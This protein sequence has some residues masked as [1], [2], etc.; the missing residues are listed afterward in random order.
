M[1]AEDDTFGVSPDGYRL[2]GAMRLGCVRL[3][4]SDLARSGAYYQRVIGLQ[5][6]DQTPGRA[7]LGAGGLAGPLIELHE[8]PHVRPVPRRGRIGLFH[9]AV[10]LPDRASLGRFIAHV[11]DLGEPAGT[12][13]HAVS[14]SVYLWDPDGLGIEVYAD[15]P[16]SEWRR[17]GR[18]L[19]MTTAPLDIDDL[20]SAAAGERWTGVPAGTLM[21]HVHLHVGDL[22]RAEAFYHSTLGFDKTVWSYPGAL[23]FAAGGYHHHLGTNIWAADT[24][25]AGPG[26]A[27]LLEWEIVLDDAGQAEAAARSCEA[28]GF[29]VT[30]RD[31]GFLVPDPWGLV[32]R[33]T[34]KPA[35]RGQA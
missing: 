18:E 8:E 7:A 20:I 24:R 35:K 32:L 19:Y 30:R 29:A 11:G 21:G 33:V 22:N 16:H 2:P 3:A 10:L 14:Q 6:L 27:R 15:R 4:V 26:D 9:F 1:H 17:R 13:D 28:G 34:S 23:F 5:I 25:V 31:S 12:A